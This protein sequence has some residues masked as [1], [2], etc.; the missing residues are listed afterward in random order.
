VVTT[1][2]PEEIADADEQVAS[3]AEWL[4]RMR[5]AGRAGG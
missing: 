2:A 1:H 4:D 3:V 5:A